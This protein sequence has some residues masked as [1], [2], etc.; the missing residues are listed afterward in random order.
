MK[1]SNCP[2]GM[3]KT[4][5]D[6]CQPLHAGE[7]EAETPEQ[8]MRARYCAFAKHEFDFLVN[9]TDPQIRIEVNHAGNEEWAK[10]A[11]FSKLEV[12]STSVDG[13]KGFVEFKAHYAQNGENH[14][15]HEKAKFRRH[16][17][18]W[19]FRDGKAVEQKTK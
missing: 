6:C 12:L 4:Y 1:N 14:V 3:E 19:F 7:A 11:E 8:L 13:N 15:H 5:E 17:G 2:C 9:S 10:T 16:G 18:E